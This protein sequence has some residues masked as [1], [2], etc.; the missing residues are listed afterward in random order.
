MFQLYGQ[1]SNKISALKVHNDARK[2]VC[3]TLVWS[4]NL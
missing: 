2:E 4:E 3:T 1:S